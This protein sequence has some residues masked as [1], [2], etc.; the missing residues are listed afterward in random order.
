DGQKAEELYQRV[1]KSGLFDRKLQMYKTSVPMEHISMENGRIR[2]FT[3]GWLERES[4][5]LH[6]EYKYLLSMLKAGLYERFYEDLPTALVAFRDPKQYG[7][8]ILE[9]S[10]FLA[11]SE[12][13]DETLHGRGY[14][15][16][17]SGSTTEAISIWIGMFIGDRIF[18]YEDGQ[19]ML[20]LEPKLPGWMFDEAGNVSFTL[21]SHCKVTYHNPVRKATY[22]E[23]AARVRKI[24]IVD[25]GMY[26]NAGYLSGPLAEGVRNGEIKEL[27]AYL[28]D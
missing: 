27:I 26:V 16:R 24:E 7:R 13:P 15:A 17:L 14:V 6:M 3:P 22:G 9:N 10:S 18:T 11:S 28:E 23:N 12:N 4:I 20:H 2:A 19:L 21:L 1:R 5:F 8:S 25:T